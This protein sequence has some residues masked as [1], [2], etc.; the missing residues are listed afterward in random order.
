VESE[1][2]KGTTFYFSIPINMD[3]IIAYGLN[4]PKEEQA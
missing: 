1:V 2:G 3:E 4:L